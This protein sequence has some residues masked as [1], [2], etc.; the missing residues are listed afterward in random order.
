M[1]R[2]ATIRVG[3]ASLAESVLLPGSDPR[4]KRRALRTGAAGSQDESRCGAIH[5][6]RSYQDMPD[7]V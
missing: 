3:E 4:R 1:R 7:S 5:K 6:Q 2:E